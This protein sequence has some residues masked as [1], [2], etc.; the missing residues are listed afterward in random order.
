LQILV[1]NRVLGFG[2][3]LR[4]YLKNCVRRFFE[5]AID[6]MQFDVVDLLVSSVG[7][8]EDDPCS[9]SVL[10]IVKLE[11][12]IRNASRRQLGSASTIAEFQAASPR[13]GEILNGLDLG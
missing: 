10:Q 11:T 1:G 12:P 5:E 7:H 8:V 9:C 3:W 4:G 6:K 2:L 13:H